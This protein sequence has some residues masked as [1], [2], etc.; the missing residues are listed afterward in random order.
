[1]LAT[2]GECSAVR[3]AA[4]AN[5]H[6]CILVLG[7]LWDAVAQDS[8]PARQTTVFAL[9]RVDTDGPD[10]EFQ[11]AQFQLIKGRPALKLVLMR[12]EISKLEFIRKLPDPLVWLERNLRIDFTSDGKTME[13]ALRGTERREL[14]IVVNAVT[15]VYLA[16]VLAETDRRVKRLIDQV[17]LE[18]RKL[19]EAR[20]N[21]KKPAELLDLEQ[22]SFRLTV[23]REELRQGIVGTVRLLQKAHAGE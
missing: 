16:H 10:E 6:L 8:V 19:L 14:A 17:E 3:G 23:L 15:E 21:V 1:M 5:A 11:R 4:M 22:R 9:L 2:A 12:G 7:V 20:Q 13:I 18:R